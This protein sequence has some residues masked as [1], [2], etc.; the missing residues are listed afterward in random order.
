MVNVQ[1]Y[2]KPFARL[3]DRTLSVRDL[4]RSMAEVGAT[5]FY[6]KIGEPVLFKID[7][8][9][10]RYKT[11]PLT[12]KHL[13]HVI[14][15]FFTQADADRFR[16]RREVDLVHAEGDTRYRVHIGT[17]NNG[18]YGVIR[19]ISQDVWPLE[20]IGL[21]RNA[22]APL[23]KLRSGLIL[24]AGA[25]GQGK[26]MTA[27]SLLDH[28]NATRPATLLTLE[29]PIEYIFEDKQGMF[30]QRE[31]G[32]HVETFADGVQAGLRE[33]LDVIYVGEMREPKTIEQ[34]LKAAEMGHLVISTIHAEDTV[35]ALGRIIGSF[36]S[37]HH[38]RIQYT[39][40]AG[41]SAVITQRL[42]P[43]A[44]TGR[45]LCAEV[46][47]P[48]TAIRSVLRS[49]ELTKLPIYIGQPGSGVIYRDH[50]Q[51]LADARKITRNVRDEELVHYQSRRAGGEESAR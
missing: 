17:A 6:L 50:L 30:I 33:A 49:G 19:R 46:L 32:M 1:A 4:L 23:K 8:S 42:L 34:V 48:T 10:T 37:E 40:G 47:F 12:E 44:R 38:A 18:A 5:D 25:T 27:V 43:S 11:D 15:C 2:D 16:A 13:S 14:A 22:V 24:I 21:P 3:G 35:S 31:V 20:K 7:G 26:T 29:D 28:I 9:L 51:E 45:V 41:I 36:T 39:L